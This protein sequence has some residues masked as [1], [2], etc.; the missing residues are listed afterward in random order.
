MII[1][2]II[3]LIK[4]FVIVMILLLRVSRLYPSGARRWF[5]SCAVGNPAVRVKAQGFNHDSHPE[6]AN[7]C[8]H[9]FKRANVRAYVQWITRNQELVKYKGWHGM[10]CTIWFGMVRLNLVQVITR[11]RSGF[12]MVEKHAEISKSHS[13]HLVPFPPFPRW[14]G[15]WV[16]HMWN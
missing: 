10:L 7:Y 2:I 15:R 5:E 1:A 9:H 8:M 6:S 12:G 13:Q 16:E 11:H 4:K 3:K 14:E